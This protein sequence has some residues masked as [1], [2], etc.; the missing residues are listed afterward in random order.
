MTAHYHSSSKLAF[1][2]QITKNNGF[3]IIVQYRREPESAKQKKI[4]RTV[5]RLA[6]LSRMRLFGRP[7]IKK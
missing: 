6:A 4:T 2:A 1:M 5:Q 3:F 7:L